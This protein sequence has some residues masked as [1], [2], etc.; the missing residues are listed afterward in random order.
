M[1]ALR[2]RLRAMEPRAAHV[3]VMRWVDGR[4]R[5]ECAA[6]FGIRPEA[7][8]VK[9]WRAT[10][11]LLEPDARM[12]RFES[13]QLAAAA[14]ARAMDGG[15]AAEPGVASAATLASELRAHA[16]ALRAA[17]DAAA[18]ADEDSPARRRED[19]LRRGAIVLIVAL[20]AFFY[21]RGRR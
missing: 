17:L 10:R 15:A 2:D 13:E 12:E 4:S 6:A 16:P 7:F 11:A 9:L 19:W 21:L 1:E 8:D 20:T 18:R 5:A 14:L 3:L